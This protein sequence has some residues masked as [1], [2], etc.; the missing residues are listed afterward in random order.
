MKVQMIPE[1]RIIDETPNYSG[2]DKNLISY[3]EEPISVTHFVENPNVESVIVSLGID[4][5]NDTANIDI[6]EGGGNPKKIDAGSRFPGVVN[7]EIE[8]GKVNEK[9]VTIQHYKKRYQIIALVESPAVVDIGNPDSKNFES[10]SYK[11]IKDLDK[12]AIE[13]GVFDPLK[14]PSAFDVSG[15]EETP[16]RRYI[17]VTKLSTETN[18]ILVRNK[19]VLKRLQKLFQ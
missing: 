3:D 7:I 4:S 14:L 13:S 6:K 9:G 12:D 8:I 17:K 1:K 19:S 5:L 18:S 11:F 15:P 10:S 16:T 2:W